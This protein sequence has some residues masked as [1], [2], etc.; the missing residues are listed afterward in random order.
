MLQPG[1]VLT[2]RWG[3]SWRVL[4]DFP[5]PFYILPGP[6]AGAGAPLITD[7]SRGFRLIIDIMAPAAWPCPIVQPGGLVMFPARDLPPCPFIP[8]QPTGARSPVEGE[9]SRGPARACVIIAG[10]HPRVPPSPPSQFYVW[11]FLKTRAIF[12]QFF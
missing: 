7:T 12:P 1:P 10:G 11:V 4:I 8:A 6:G 9:G 3:T 5:A 2:W